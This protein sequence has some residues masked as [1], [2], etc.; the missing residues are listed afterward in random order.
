MFLDEA[1]V[2][3]ISGKGGDGALSF[4]REKFVPHG[5]PDGADGG[6][7]GDIVFIADRSKRTLYDFKFKPR[8]KA[9]DGTSARSNKNG[10]NAA[11]IEIHV[12]VGTIIS[13]AESSKPLVDLAVDGA[14]YV[15]CK[16]GRG[17]FGNLHYVNSVRQAPQFAQKGEPGEERTVKLE[18]KLVADIGII[19]LPNAGKSTLISRI[20]A[21]K[22]KIADYPFTTLVPNLGVVSIG[23]ES[24]TVADMP[25]LIGGA[26]EGHGLGHQFLRHV[27]R[28]AA[29]VHLVEV[30]PMDQSDPM[31]NFRVIESELKAFSEELWN[32][33]RILVLSKADTMS[34][35]DLEVLREFFLQETGEAP[36]AISAATGEGIDPLLFRLAE[37]VREAAKKPT[38]PTLFPVGDQDVDASFWDVVRLNDGFEIVGK[39]IDRLVAMTDL[40]NDDAVRFMHRKLERIG[41]INKLRELGAQDGDEVYAGD[42]VF[43]F[44]DRS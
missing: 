37:L 41:V 30:A 17:G 7:G 3:L 13:D 24:F 15:A 25:G 29:L 44:E 38:V 32:R 40:E 39:R 34:P 1:T 27:E 42:F 10:K 18:L 22:P 2:E 23:D 21:A 26:S 43:T 11:N 19:G 20:S 35:E 5:G 12:P 14:R 28:C 31:E 33:D 8:F 16:G 4:H 6:R 36:L 9:E